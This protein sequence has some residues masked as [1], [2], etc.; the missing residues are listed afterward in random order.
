LRHKYVL[1]LDYLNKK[2]S[3]FNLTISLRAMRNDRSRSNI[4]PI[5]LI[6]ATILKGNGF[7]LIFSAIAKMILPPSKAG[8]G[9]IFT[10]AK[11][12]ERKAKK[13]KK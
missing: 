13:L 10:M 7:F 9:R 3:V 6:A 11:F 4:K 8:K 5:P 1:I 12:V 2:E